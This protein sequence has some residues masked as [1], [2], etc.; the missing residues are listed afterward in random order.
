M[1]FLITAY[2]GTDSEA[3]ARRNNV[4][5]RHLEGAKKLIK[6]RKWLYAAAILD[7]N[8]K[9]IGSMVIADYPSKEALVNGWLNDEP[10]VTGDVWKEIDIRPCNVLDFVLDTG[11]IY[12]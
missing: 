11:W 5:E 12:K 6:E 8:G 7:D 2:D 10:Y 1:H 3:I 9:M 4:R